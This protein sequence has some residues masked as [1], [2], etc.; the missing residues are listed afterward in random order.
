MDF[1][2]ARSRP[3]PYEETVLLRRVRTNLLELGDVRVKAMRDSGISL[4][5]VSHAALGLALDLETCMKVNNEIAQ[6]AKAHPNTLK[7]FATLP[8]GD[9]SAACQEFKRCVKDLGF[10][11]ALI[12]NTCEGRFY[13][14]SFFWCVFETAQELDVPLYIHPSY[15]DQTKELL[16]DDNYPNELAQTLASYVWGWHSEN[17]L[18]IIRLFAAGIFDKFPRLKIIIGHMGEML[19]FQLDRAIRQTSQHWPLA[20]VKLERQLRQVWDEN[21]WITTSGMF[22]VTPMATV[23]RQCKPDHI[24]FSVDYPFARNEWGVK[25]LQD[26]KDEGMVSDELLEGICYK[27]AEKLLRVKARV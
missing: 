7:G 14:D 15:N 13:D 3:D 10:P 24:L 23:L 12:D 19:P 2:A 4:Q 22:S 25:M 5:I 26:L 1:Y 16:H 6:A 27:N 9:P 20:G 8:M 11:G 21:I 17:A 18:H